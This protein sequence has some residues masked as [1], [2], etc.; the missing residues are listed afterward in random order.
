MTET[1]IESGAPKQGNWL[2]KLIWLGGAFVILLVVFY[3]VATSGA[4]FKGV[5]LPKVSNSL[6]ADV[7]VADAQIS[8]FSRVVLR[9]LKVQPRGGEP[10]LTVR[11]VRA[12]YSLWSIIGGKIVVQEAVVESPVVT[13]V[14][15]ADGSSNLDAL[16]KAQTKEKKPAPPKTSAPSKPA[17]V[18]IKKVAL[19]NATV[20]F[21]KNY[22]GGTRD[23]T[24]VTGL[25]FSVSDLKNGQSGKIELAAALAMEKAAQPPA[26]AGSLQA[27]LLGSFDFALTSDLKPASAKGNTTFTVEKA[28]GPLA[29][30]GALA[31]KF[32]CELTS[33]ELKQLAMRFTKA[34][35][36]LGEVRA[37]GPFDTAKSEGKLKLEILGIDKRALNLVG[38]AGGMDFGTTT[39]SSS[40]DIEFSKG[41]SLISTVGRLDVAHFQMTRQNQTSPTLD[42]RGDYAVTLDQTASVIVLKTLNLTGT[43]NSR[44]LLQSELSSPMTI[45]FGNSSSAVGDAA[46]NLS[47]TNLNLADWKAFSGDA[48]PEGVAGVKA[49]LVSQKAGQQLAFELDA[50]LDNLAT[51]K[52][53]ARVNHGNLRAQLHGGAA[54]LKQFKLDDYQLNLDQQGQS[55]LKISGSGTFDS[56]TQDADFQ[57]AMQTALA[58]LLGSPGAS[59]TDGAVDFKGRVTNKQKKVT[60]A[61]KLALTPTDRAKNE[62]QLDGNVDVS[63]ADAITGNIKVSA[64]SLDVTRYY[65]LLSNNKTGQTSPQ[66]APAA[67]PS[68]D[69]NKEPEAI[70]LPFKNF[71][72]D[73]NIGRLFLYEVDIAN[74][75]TTALLDGGHVVVKPCQLT[76]NNAPIK[77][78]ADLDLG[79]PGYKYDVAFN[80]NAIPLA[81]LVNSFVPDRKG[82]LGGTTTADAQL[83]GAGIT[84]AS[85]Q[86]NLAGQL[87]FATTNM[88][89]SIANVRSPVLNSVINVIV[90]IPDLLRN[91]AATLGN[92][93]GGLTGSAKSKGGWADELT[94]APIDVISVSAKAGDGRVQLQQAEVR[95]KAFEVQAAGDVTLAP[96]LTNSAIQIPVKVELARAMADKIGLVS[97][98]TPTNAVYVA[99][100]DFLKMQGTVGNP[101]ANIDKLAL[102]TLAARTGGGVA[103][104]IGSAGGEAVGSVINKVGGLFGGRSAP[105]TGSDTNSPSTTTNSKPAPGLLDFF[106]KPK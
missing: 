67:A 40:S 83:K 94:A 86:K 56:D 76:L 25:N 57:I 70:K 93:L 71:T 88:N 36:T 45:S 37:S 75:Q 8:P 82:Q 44:P 52:G 18:D 12:S 14:E 78:T 35:E 60:L 43:Q 4:F 62:L 5:I 87:N 77:A 22:Q 10:L 2:R 59:P 53:D 63:K 26:A 69:S 30:L 101:K 72:F 80:A 79:V 11:E 42:L 105:P 64:E 27:K 58:R 51:G 29:D 89:L 102:I 100:P 99:L 16:L 48:A 17:Q 13:V 7:T 85:L 74:W 68:S 98:D 106:K 84:G 97:A 23:V 15:N 34:S 38:A 21:V 61:G 103:K 55:A 54:N 73:L 90:A 46:L 41:G 47:V 28:T 66:P 50:H 39:I 81:P 96:I 104:N 20:R 95:S 9:D 19:N 24:E 3:F 1:K 92:L 65:D 6:G 31:A 33:T 91:P 32:D 49:K